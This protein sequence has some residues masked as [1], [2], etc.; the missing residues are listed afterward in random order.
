VTDVLI[1]GSAGEFAPNERVWGTGGW[2]PPEQREALDWL[3]LVRMLGW[4]VRTT[5]ELR[6]QVPSADVVIVAVE[7]SDAEDVGRTLL[8]AAEQGALVV[9]P[10][11]HA[12]QSLVDDGAPAQEISL[13][14]VGQGRI[15]LL[16]F[17]PSQAR[18]EA[19]STTARLVEL[20]TKNAPA[21]TAWLDL[22]GTVVLRMD[23][24]GGA[25][26]VYSKQWSYPKLTGSQYRAAGEILARRDARISLAYSPGFVDDG[27]PARGRLLVEDVEPTR[28][29]GRVHPSPLVRYEDV[30][31]H[32]PGTVYDY[33]D[34]YAGIAG[35]IRSD[36][37]SVELHGNTHIHPDFTE[38]LAAEDRYD[39]IDWYRELGPAAAPAI[40]R[41]P[42]DRHPLTLGYE[43]IER[44]FEQRPTTLVSPG[45][46][47]TNEALETALGLGISLVA[48][49]YLALQHDDR[50]CWSTHICSPYLDEPDGTWFESP[51]PV[52]GYMHDRDLVVNGVGWLDEWMDAWVQ[53]GARRFID[54]RQLAG[55]LGTPVAVESN[56]THETAG[57]WIQTRTSSE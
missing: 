14:R 38:W 52:V 44:W 55:L 25:Q 5:T 18:D 9:S 20:L 17:H 27:D 28:E 12:P 50:L 29:P 19:R 56:E 1:V 4:T 36:R 30:A 47:W 54:F 31:G 46:E 40:A 51:L 23:D 48:S 13:R 35:L 53:A 42:L 21:P 34:E 57:P 10:R 6:P 11:D 33:S 45:D 15:A 3:I 24:P 39:S 26:N 41:L 43:A 8:K 16:D 49:Y 32:A 22:S 37:A 7:L 2:R